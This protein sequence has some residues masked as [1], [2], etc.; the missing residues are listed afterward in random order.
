ME[1]FGRPLVLWV[2]CL[3]LLNGCGTV[4]QIDWKRVADRNEK[5]L[6][7]AHNRDSGKVTPL[8]CEKVR[9]S[10]DGQEW[11]LPCRRVQVIMP[12]DKQKKP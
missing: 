3:V 1:R 7:Y 6:V 9:L 5:D 4:F 12:P 2:C 10:K 11:E 8:L